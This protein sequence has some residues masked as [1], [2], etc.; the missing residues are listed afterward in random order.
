MRGQQMNITRFSASVEAVMGLVLIVDPALVASLLLGTELSAGGQAVGR[1]AGFALVALALACW[2]QVEPPNGN[3][4]PAV[5]GLLVY[6]TF[7]AIF[8]IYVGAR[9]EFAGLLLW[10]AAALHAVLAICFARIFFRGGL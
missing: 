10:P 2:P 7:A 9:R 3:P 5:R 4:S 6:N 8:F 1:V